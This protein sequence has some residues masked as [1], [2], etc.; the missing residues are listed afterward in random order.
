MQPDKIKPP[1]TIKIGLRFDRRDLGRLESLQGRLE[2]GEFEGEP[3][4]FKYA[5]D[6]S[7]FGDP[8]VVEC[9]HPDEARQIAAQFVRL[10]CSEPTLA[11][12]SL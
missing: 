7:R 2:G 12:L 1:P 9:E 5:A 8:L 6:A 11:E 3:N 4:L 10:G